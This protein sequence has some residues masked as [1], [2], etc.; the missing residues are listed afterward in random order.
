MVAV[1]KITTVEASAVK[2]AGVASVVL[3]LRMGVSSPKLLK[4]RLKLLMKRLIKEAEVLPPA[5]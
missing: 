2:V 3:S 5:T 4:S 1:V